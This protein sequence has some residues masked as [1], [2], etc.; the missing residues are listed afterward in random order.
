MAQLK[1][2][3]VFLLLFILL[4]FLF[5]EGVKGQRA[6]ADLKFSDVSNT[7]LL[8]R[9]G[10]HEYE[11]LM[12]RKRTSPY[13]KCWEDAILKLEKSCQQLDENIQS[14]LAVAFTHCFLKTSGMADLLSAEACHSIIQP[15]Q[16]F[17]PSLLP[18]LKQCVKSIDLRIFQT[19]SLFYVHTQSIC[20]YL[21]SEQWQKHTE[22]LV[23][24]LV[25]TAQSVSSNLNS[26]VSTI[27]QLEE[28]QHSSLQAQVS[29][30]EELATAKSSL[31]LFQ[32]QTKEQRDLIE[33]ILDQ[34]VI[35][36]Q[37]LVIEFSANSAVVYYIFA[38]LVIYFGTTHQRVQSARLILY[39]ML[40]VN[41][42][43]EK[44]AVDFLLYL[45]FII[46]SPL[47]NSFDESF[48]VIRN[49]W[50]IRKVMVFLMA[51]TYIWLA[52]S[53]RDITQINYRI[54]NENTAILRNIQSQLLSPPKPY[55]QK[56]LTCYS[57]DSDSQSDESDYESDFSDDDESFT[58]S[59]VESLSDES[60]KSPNS[61]RYTLR[62]STKTS[63][64]RALP[65]EYENESAKDF[66]RVVR[67]SL[68]K[69][70]SRERLNCYSSDDEY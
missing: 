59:E 68:K 2:F 35:L 46:N 34:F 61:T 43:L 57:D 58:L 33:K 4:L 26:A 28:L 50:T 18:Q 22:N 55:G 6:S 49:I 36:R 56:T 12:E 27:H 60:D 64:Y 70:A 9:N 3:S 14:W 23:D 66:A 44:K 13:G 8:A 29:L 63:N 51:S 15:R 16:Q 32:E 67:T 65:K 54:L 38:M 52:I 47:L 1:C 39:I 11:A 7:E 25:H 10:K 42:V 17:S 53:Y 41:F 20:F 62:S 5:N 45:D 37:F 24:N 69:S 48:A 40:A 30:N 19:Y 31:Q 21:H